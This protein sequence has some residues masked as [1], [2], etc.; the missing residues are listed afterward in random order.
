[1]KLKII[2]KNYNENNEEIIK[3]IIV[4]HQLIKFQ[5]NFNMDFL[6]LNIPLKFF[7]IE[8]EKKDDKKIIT[9]HYQNEE[10]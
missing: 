5:K 3:N 8:E 2:L 4:S 7:I 6:F 10:Y 9:V 1:M